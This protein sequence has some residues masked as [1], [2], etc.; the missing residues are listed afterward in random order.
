MLGHVS[1]EG[2]QF[3]AGFFF[4]SIVYVPELRNHLSDLYDRVEE[5]L[6]WFV[7]FFLCRWHETWRLRYAQRVK[8]IFD[9]FLPIH[10]DDFRISLWSLLCFLYF[11]YFCNLGVILWRQFFLNFLLPFVYDICISL[12][13]LLRM[14][15]IFLF[16]NRQNMS[17]LRFKLYLLGLL[18]R[19]T[20][21]R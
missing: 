21:R 12:L 7:L 6:Y 15:L 17:I 8:P 18:I 9:F 11:L 5:S 4:G 14:F 20:I 2:E 13:F 19:M 16:N 1:L 3:L 10:V